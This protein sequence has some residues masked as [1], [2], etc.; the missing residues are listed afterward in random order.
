M[1]EGRIKYCFPAW[2]RLVKGTKDGLIVLKGSIAALGGKL[3]QTDFSSRWMA[4]D[5]V[6]LLWL[7]TFLLLAHSVQQEPQMFMGYRSH[8]CHCIVFIPERFFYFQ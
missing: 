2:F 6:C 4:H 3:D 8:L 5:T 1:W 7:E